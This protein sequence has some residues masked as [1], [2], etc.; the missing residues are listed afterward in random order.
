MNAY[1]AKECGLK[2]MFSVNSKSEKNERQV[3]VMHKTRPNDPE[4]SEAS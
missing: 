4:A 1:D 2:V 3:E